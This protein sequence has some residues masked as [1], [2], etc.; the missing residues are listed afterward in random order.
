MEKLL[1]LLVVL[2]TVLGFAGI[3]VLA[4]RRVRKSSRRAAFLGGGVQ[5]WVPE[6]ILCLRRRFSSKK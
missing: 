3:A 6:S 1:P 4:V 2:V 5:F